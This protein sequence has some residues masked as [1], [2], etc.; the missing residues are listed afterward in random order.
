MSN[1]VTSDNYMFTLPTIINS[2]TKTGLCKETQVG[3]LNLA[4]SSTPI[5]HNFAI[6]QHR[7]EN[8]TPRPRWTIAWSYLQRL[9]ADKRT[10]DKTKTS[11]QASSYSH[12]SLCPRKDRWSVVR[13]SSPILAPTRS[14]NSD[15]LTNTK[16][17][18]PYSLQRYSKVSCG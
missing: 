17:C 14:N 4:Q 16:S 7:S 13:H 1:T 2:S 5:M 8:V 18:L 6:C 11:Q 15:F 3:S 12:K 9:L 10:Q